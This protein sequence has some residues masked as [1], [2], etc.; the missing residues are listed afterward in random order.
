MGEWI[1]FSIC[2][3][4]SFAKSKL[5]SSSDSSS[6][7]FV[8]LMFVD[9]VILYWGQNLL[10]LANKFPFCVGGEQGTFAD[11]SYEKIISTILKNMRTSTRTKHSPGREGR[12]LRRLSVL[13]VE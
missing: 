6:L 7:E 5:V 2:V 12:E 10:D 8:K 3:C 1:Q 11:A 13:H 9:T 4:Q